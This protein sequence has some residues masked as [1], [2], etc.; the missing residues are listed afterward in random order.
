[1]ESLSKTILMLISISLVAINAHASCQAA[2][3]LAVENTVY[4]GNPPDGTAIKTLIPNREYK[5]TVGI[6][7]N[8]S[9][10]HTYIVKF[11]DGTCNPKT[12]KI[13]EIAR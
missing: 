1:M 11:T 9:G 12:A 10:P 7:N 13:V 6:R 8:E 3:L 2:A 5:V 4:A